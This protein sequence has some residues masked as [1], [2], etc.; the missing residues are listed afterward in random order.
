RTYDEPHEMFGYLAYPK[1]SW[2]LRML[3]GQLG[4]D[5]Y[6]RCIKTWLERY[7][8]ENVTTEDLR[9]VVEEL[10]GN[11]YDQFFDQWLYHAHHPELNVSQSW[12]ERTKLVKVSISQV[13]RLSDNVLLFNFPLAVRFKG[14]F[15]TTDRLIRVKAK[16]EDFYFPLESAPEIVRIDP[17]YTLLAKVSFDLPNAMLDAQLADGTDVIGRLLAIEQL[18]NRKSKD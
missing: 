9:K 1:G 5:L 18:S 12:D 17:D 16:D 10:S 8:H 7:H 15:G 3:R 6:R 11:S 14:K 4:D 2:V 13:Q